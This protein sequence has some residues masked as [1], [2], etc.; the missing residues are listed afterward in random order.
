M[1]HCR[2][3][4][5]RAIVNASACVQTSILMLVHPLGRVVLQVSP[6]VMHDIAIPPPFAFVTLHGLLVPALPAVCSAGVLVKP[7]PVAAGSW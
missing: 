6:V 3:T 1:A 7:T 2:A 4:T 5:T